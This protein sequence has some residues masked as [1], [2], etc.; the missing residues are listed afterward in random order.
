MTHRPIPLIEVSGTPRERGRAYGEAARSEIGRSLDYYRVAFS[1]SSGLSW[2]EVLDRARLWRPVVEAAAPRLA[3]EMDG[4]AEG[5]GADATDILALNARGEIVRSADSS[6]AEMGRPAAPHQREEIDGCSSFAL[7]PEAT[8]DGHTYVGQNWDWRAGTEDTTVMIRI[9]QPPLPTVIMQVEAG[10]VGRHGVNSAGIALNANGLDGRFGTP[11]G[12]PQPLMRRLILDAP[13]FHEALDIPFAV[14][15]HIA[16]NLVL[17]HRDGFAIDLETTPLGHGW[18]YPRD[19][20]LVHGNHYQYGI[21]PALWA[22]YRPSS[23]DSLVRVPRIESGLARVRH[24]AD[25]TAVRKAVHD[26]MSDHFGAPLSVCAHPDPAHGEVRR[27]KTIM[28]SLVDL[29]AGEYHALRGNPCESD[30]RL[31]PWNLY[32]GPGGER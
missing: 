29:T 2:P 12:L 32:D 20:I 30:Y 1:T 31:L 23:P 11:L 26:A 15:Q 17:A 9:V 28:S 27:S 10:Q 16:T 24:A 8:G 7:L 14:R 5:A 19:G 18:G 25:P 3:E 22:D 21:P 4:I 6:F 13:T